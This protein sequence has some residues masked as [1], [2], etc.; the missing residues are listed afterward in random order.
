MAWGRAIIDAAFCRHYISV[1]VALQKER[2]RTA[3]AAPLVTF[4]FANRLLMCIHA[5]TPYFFIRSIYLS[6]Y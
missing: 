3:T 1:H 5:N 6:V 4:F 2:S